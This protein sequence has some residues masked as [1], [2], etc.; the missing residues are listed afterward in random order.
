M[1]KAH[2]HILITGGSGAVGKR[3][4]DLLISKGYPVSQL[5]RKPAQDTR[6]KNFLW[7][8]PTGRIDAE[9]IDGIDIIIHLAGASIADKKWTKER[10]REIIDSRTESIRLIY[11]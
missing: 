3:L 11:R 10:K 1:P 2:P 8:V 9:C 4:T 5:N 7:D 6:V